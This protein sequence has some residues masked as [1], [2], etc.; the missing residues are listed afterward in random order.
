MSDINIDLDAMMSQVDN[1]TTSNVVAEPVAPRVAIPEAATQPSNVVSEP[2]APRVSIPEAAPHPETIQPAIN[3]STPQPETIQTAINISTPETP[4]HNNTTTNV[5]NPPVINGDVIDFSIKNDRY[6]IFLNLFENLSKFLPGINIHKSKI[7]QSMNNGSAFII[8]NNI[9]EFPE[10]C[11]I[12]INNLKNRIP[13]LKMFNSN[14]KDKNIKINSKDNSL[15]IWDDNT[16]INL[17]LAS[18]SISAEYQYISDERWSKMVDI[19]ANSESTSFTISP[20]LFDRFKILLNSFVNPMTKININ[21]SN[22]ITLQIES[23]NKIEKGQVNNF[24]KNT[25]ENIKG[26]TFDFNAFLFMLDVTDI[27][28]TLYADIKNGRN[29]AIMLFSCKMN[30]YDFELYQKGVYKI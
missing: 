15:F 8:C 28:I 10:I 12:N 24:A 7:R 25:N 23:S 27:K 22:D 14:G 30:G 4:V 20:I 29:G 6:D 16:Q 19:M 2:V 3:T 17:S 5:T 21:K 1:L 18:Q 13:L 9:P 11:D 26:F